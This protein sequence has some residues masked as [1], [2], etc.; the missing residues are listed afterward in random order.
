[1]TTS[2][3]HTGALEDCEHTV[4][5]GDAKVDGKIQRPAEVNVKG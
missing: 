5:T 3:E 1:M 2:F 4:E